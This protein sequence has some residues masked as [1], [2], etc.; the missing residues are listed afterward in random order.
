MKL[1]GAQFKWWKD[2]EDAEKQGG[3]MSDGGW[4]EFADIPVPEWYGRWQDFLWS[5][6]IPPAPHGEEK[7]EPKPEV[8]GVV[9]NAAKIL[10]KMGGMKTRER[11][12]EYYSMIGRM[13]GRGHRK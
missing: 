4:I 5:E 12:R 6:E 2:Y 7:V 11:G 13:G 10:G 3:T 9:F 8:P 1:T